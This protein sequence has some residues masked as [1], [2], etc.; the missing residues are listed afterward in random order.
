MLEMRGAGEQL[1][2]GTQARRPPVIHSR[3]VLQSAPLPP[4]STSLRLG[5]MP[6]GCADCATLA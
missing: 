1:M 5:L 6:V 2:L 3:G 4:C